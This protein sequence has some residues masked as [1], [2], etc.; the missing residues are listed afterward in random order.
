[1][2]KKNICC[3]KINL[4]VP[5]KLRSLL[6]CGRILD[7]ARKHN[8]F[9][10]NVPLFSIKEDFWLSCQILRNRKAFVIV[11]RISYITHLFFRACGYIANLNSEQLIES[12]EIIFLLLKNIYYLCVKV[13]RFH[14]GITIQ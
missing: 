4:F 13:S 9:L 10:E 6:I 11:F 7:A 12:Q 1:M 3:V 14:K 5:I 8:S 2:L